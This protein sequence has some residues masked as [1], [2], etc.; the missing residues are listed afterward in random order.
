MKLANK[1]GILTGASRGIGVVLAE[2][3][4]RKGT[5][6]VLA[7]RSK[8]DLEQT[9]ELVRKQGRRAL[10]VA[11]DVSDVLQLR[12]LVDA[13]TTEFGRVDLL[14]NNAGIE[15]PGHSEALDL[16]HI[17][18]AVHTNLTALI[19]LTRLVIP[20]MVE[21]G[22]GHVCNISSAAGKVARPFATVYAATKHGVVGF[23]WSLRAELAPLGVEV[24]V[25]CPGYV[26]DVGMFADRTAKLGVEMP[27]RSLKAVSGERVV[28]QV[29]ESIEKNRAETVVGPLL[30]KV[31]GVAHAISPDF[32]IGVARRSGA[33]EYV[34][35]EATGERA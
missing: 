24:T 1:I 35:R 10:P 11:T 7:A 4:A 8:D 18:A 2:H 30:M 16:D 15:I 29:I 28:A 21:R 20:Q 19:Q 31:A 12:A 14:V 32:A 34:R 9:A 26:A 33:Y 5:D 13:A 25:V 6:L 17:E 22:S 3:L 27:P 23:S